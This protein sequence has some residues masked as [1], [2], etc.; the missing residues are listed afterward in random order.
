MLRPVAVLSA[1]ALLGA[2]TA[3][4]ADP[5][6][7]AAIDPQAMAALVRVQKTMLSLRS[8]QAECDT[9]LTY[10][11][12]DGKPAR[13]RRQVSTLQAAKPNEMR[14]QLSYFQQDAVTHQWA[15]DPKEHG[16]ITY[17]CDG[18]TFW[19]Q[20]GNHY[21]ESRD[22]AP[23]YLTT[24]LEP[25]GGFYRAGD[26]PIGLID[27]YRKEGGLLELRRTESDTVDGVPC[28]TVFDRIKTKYED[29]TQEW[30]ETWYIGSDGLVRRHVERI[31]F[32]GKPGYTRD[33]T[34]RNIR[35]DQPIAAT[36]FAYVPPPGV[37]SEAQLRAEQPA[38]LA[39]GTAAPDF[40]AS[41][42]E[43]KPVK[44][45]DFRGKVVVIDFWASWCPP[46]RASMPHSQEVTQKLQ[47]E[48]LPVVLLAVDNSED[49]DAFSAWVGKNGATYS[50]LTFAHVPPATD[51]IGKLYHVSGIPTQYVLDKNGVV[52]ASFVGYGGPTDDLE[53]AVRDA[54]KQH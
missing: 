29:Q 14:Y 3:A 33:S 8:Y 41:D 40:T 47:A 23:Q 52:R 10:P 53:R 11:P 19:R 45:S 38:L 18:R 7:T 54:L 24:I 51:V 28:E 1:F 42:M 35:L 48:G 12:R 30:S 9:T 2:L 31:E 46:C 16:G 44:P 39:K 5:N 26:S 34:I 32:D 13:E 43:N 15:L 49:R 27:S 21:E 6:T 4:G 37:K 36:R 17:A 25:W 50:A 20:Y 22:T